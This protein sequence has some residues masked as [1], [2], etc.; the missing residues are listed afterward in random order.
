MKQQLYAFLSVMVATTLLLS[1]C[2]GGKVAQSRLNRLSNPDASPSDLQ[3]LVNGSSAF[4]FDLFQSMRASTGNLIYSPYSISLAFAMT[5]GGARGATAEQMA[6]VLHYPLPAAQFHPAFNALDLDL[7]ARPDQAAGVEA[8]D[9]FQLTIANSLWGQDGWPFRPE[10][11]DLLA[12]NYGAGMHLVDFANASESARRQINDWVAEQTKK[13]IKDIIPAGALDSSTRL[14]L[15]NAIYFKAAWQYQFDANATSEQPFHLVDGSTVSVPM[16]SQG[17]SQPFAYAAG[18]GW[19]AVALPYKGGLAEMLLLVPDAGTF[20]AFETTLTADRYHEI[21][22]ALEPQ[23]VNLSMPKFEFE[24][25]IGL[26][27]ILA[28]MG[29]TDAFDPSLADFSGMDGQRSLYIGDALHKAFIAVDENGT[30]AAAATAIIMMMRGMPAEGIK[31][32]VNRPFFFAIRDVPTGTIL[33][34]GQV[35]DPT[36][37]Q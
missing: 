33:F 26:K 11:L 4:A 20:D 17:Q 1:A 10:Y 18:D 9:R 7:A 23:P 36:A 14:V 28:S 32:T 27:D 5:Y 16:M 21:V 13:R 12:L 34:M 15:V 22:A 30:E 3:E 25:P 2:G 24:T 8:K 19:Q 29:M 6:S 31:L 37:G 35:F